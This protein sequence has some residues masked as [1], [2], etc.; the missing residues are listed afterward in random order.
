M[1]D[2]GSCDV[3]CIEPAINDESLVKPGGQVCPHL[4]QTKPH[5]KCKIYSKRPKNFCG[6]FECSWKIGYGKEDQQPSE[7]GLLTFI[8]EFNNGTWIVAI[9]VEEGGLIKGKDIILELVKMNDT[10]IIVKFYGSKV[11]TGDATII[12][13]SLLD[14]AKTMTGDFIRWIDEAETVGMYH[15]VNPGVQ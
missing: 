11:E 9:E 5:H 6:V 14:R 15:L 1:R 10:A 12:K 3:C 4:D 7:N 2:C 13:N 8:N